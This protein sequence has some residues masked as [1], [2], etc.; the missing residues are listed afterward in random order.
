VLIGR[1]SS[2]R[3]RRCVPMCGRPALLGTQSSQVPRGST[4]TGLATVLDWLGVTSCTLDG[5][6][7]RER[8]PQHYPRTT[9]SH[10][11]DRCAFSRLPL[12]P[13]EPHERYFPRLLRR[14]LQRFFRFRFTL[15]HHIDFSTAVGVRLRWQLVE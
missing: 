3:P 15:P 6:P 4:V 1:R 14:S 2:S 13:T 5:V 9:P 8:H 10:L 11:V 12:G 7:R